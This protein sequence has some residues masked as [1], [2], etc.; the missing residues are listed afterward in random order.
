M[1][2]SVAQAEP[3]LRLRPRQSLRPKDLKT[4]FTFTAKKKKIFKT[5][6]LG[7]GLLRGFIVPSGVHEMV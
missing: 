5:T 4:D 7:G 1:L 3:T 6:L 2:P